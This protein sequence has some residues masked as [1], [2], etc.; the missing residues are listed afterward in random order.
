MQLTESGLFE[1]AIQ[2]KEISENAQIKENLLLADYEEKM[3]EHIDG[4]REQTTVD[5][6]SDG[7]ETKTNE[8]LDGKPIYARYFGMEYSGSG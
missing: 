4:T 5:Y 8:R 6:K 2:A 3:S 1:K 7:T